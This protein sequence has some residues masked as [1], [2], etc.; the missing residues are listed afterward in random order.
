MWHGRLTNTSTTSGYDRREVITDH[1]WTVRKPVKGMCASSSGSTRIPTYHQ[2]IMEADIR[3][4]KEA[5]FVNL[6]DDETLMFD[7]GL[8]KTNH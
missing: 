5:Y 1:K 2:K 8:I 7:W 3:M 4:V 6:E